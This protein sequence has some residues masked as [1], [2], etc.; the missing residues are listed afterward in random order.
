MEKKNVNLLTYKL[1]NQIIY[2]TKDKIYRVSTIHLNILTPT[3]KTKEEALDFLQ[4]YNLPISDS[5]II[6]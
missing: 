2:D 4:S 5:I 1:F 6:I 3:F